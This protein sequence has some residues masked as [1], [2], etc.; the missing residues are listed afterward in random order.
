MKTNRCPHS[1]LR[2]RLPV[3]VSRQHHRHLQAVGRSRLHHLAVITLL[4]CHHLYLRRHLKVFIAFH[5]LQYHHRPAET[6]LRRYLLQMLGLYHLHLRQVAY[7][8]HL[9]HSLQALAHLR[10]RHCHQ[11][12]ARPLH[13]LCLRAVARH[14]RHLCLD[15]EQRHHYQ[16]LV[17]ETTCCRL[18]RTRAAWVEA[19][20]V[21][22]VST[23]KETAALL[24]CREPN[25][26]P[27][28]RLPQQPLVEVT[29]EE[30]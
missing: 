7:P 19:D 3:N 2:R 4:L 17:E 27:H 28:Q 20:F 30:G 15:R 10:R 6:M 23:R 16:K 9:H 5:P 21:K 24:L 8:L 25:Q 12:L 14:L 18:L 29:R 26:V 22:S 11:T 13:H 1:G